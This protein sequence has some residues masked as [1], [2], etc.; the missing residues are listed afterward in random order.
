[1]LK[2]A[3]LYESE[4]KQKFA[5]I[6]FDDRYEYYFLD[7]FQIPEIADNTYDQH[8]FVSVDKSGNVI[9]YITYSINGRAWYA[10]ELG[11]INFTNDVMTFGNDVK[12][13]IRDIFGKYNFNKLV[14]GAIKNNP[15]TEKYIKYIK[16]Y[17][18]RQLVTYN[19]HIKLK[20]GKICDYMV[21]ELSKFCFDYVKNFVIPSKKGNVYYF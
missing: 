15:A 5:G 1:M 17:N 20:S 3:I 7:G 10:Y 21:F 13:A 8:Q 16:R 14:F 12:T 11:I 19:K 9:G 6:M 4:L 2:P 18:G